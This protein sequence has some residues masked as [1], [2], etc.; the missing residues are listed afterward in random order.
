MNPQSVPQMDSGSQA[1]E[2]LTAHTPG[3][4]TQ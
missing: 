2:E 4:K 3:E 1:D